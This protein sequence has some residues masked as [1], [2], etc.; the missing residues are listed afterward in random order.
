MIN[1]SFLYYSV[2]AYICA[3]FSIYFRI[4]SRLNSSYSEH[5][6]SKSLT[7]YQSVNETC[8]TIYID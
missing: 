6:S 2:Y 8:S 4:K 5:C 3:L 7:K 1:V